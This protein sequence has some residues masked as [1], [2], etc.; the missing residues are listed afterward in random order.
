MT[1]WIVLYIF[2]CAAGEIVSKFKSGHD[3]AAPLLMENS[4]SVAFHCSQGE[5]KFHKL[6]FK[7]PYSLTIAAFA[8]L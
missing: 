3:T 1:K 7:M 4:S 2:D 5:T 6:L 8:H